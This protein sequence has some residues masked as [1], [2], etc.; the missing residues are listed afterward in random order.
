VRLHPA[1]GP[2]SIRQSGANSEGLEDQVTAAV[3][4][5]VRFGGIAWSHVLGVSNGPAVPFEFVVDMEVSIVEVPLAAIYGAI[6]GTVKFVTL[7]GY[8]VP[9]LRVS[10]VRPCQKQNKDCENGATAKNEAGISPMDHRHSALPKKQGRLRPW[11][12]PFGIPPQNTGIL[13]T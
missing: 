10:A 4:E 1:R 11:F 7:T 3:D 2:A 13:H 9:C 8:E 6:Q 12:Q 5:N